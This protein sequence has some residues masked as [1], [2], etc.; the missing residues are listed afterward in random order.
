MKQNSGLKL[1]GHKRNKLNKS[2]TEFWGSYLAEHIDQQFAK[3]SHYSKGF[4]RKFHQQVDIMILQM[5]TE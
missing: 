3:R 4:T 1:I 5:L 2:H